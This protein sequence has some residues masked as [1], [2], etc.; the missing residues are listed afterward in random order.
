MVTPP[1]P[2][3]VMEFAATHHV[4]RSKPAWITTIPEWDR[5]QYA[6]SQGVGVGTIRA[7]LL[8]LGYT[9]EEATPN[10]V[11]WLRTRARD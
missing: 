4:V 8:S 5:I 7:W 10:R 2:P 11:A 6:W 1:E 3:D 9:P